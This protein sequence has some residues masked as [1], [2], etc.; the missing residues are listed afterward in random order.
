[1]KYIFLYR[2]EAKTLFW[3]IKFPPQIRY[4][5]CCIDSSIVWISTEIASICIW[6]KLKFPF[7]LSKFLCLFLFDLKSPSC[8]CSWDESLIFMWN[9]LLPSKFEQIPKL[10]YYRLF[11]FLH[12]K[13]HREGFIECQENAKTVPK[14]QF[15]D[16]FF[17]PLWSTPF[18]IS[19]RV[20]F[21]S[22]LS[23]KISLNFIQS[24]Q[25]CSQNEMIIIFN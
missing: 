16:N 7:F 23:V 5:A 19:F 6:S 3:L 2:D 24:I 13:S 4:L 25:N 9:F 1:M 18:F 14:M 15:F 17:P 21:T 8:L 20:N 22:L 12:K 10:F 11:S